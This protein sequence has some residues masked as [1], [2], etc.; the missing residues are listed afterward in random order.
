MEIRIVM[1]CGCEWK[2]HDLD[3]PPVLNAPCHCPQHGDVEIEDISVIGVTDFFVR[4]VM[5]DWWHGGRIVSDEE[6]A[7]KLANTE[8]ETFPCF[9]KSVPSSLVVIY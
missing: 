2:W 3:V 8:H 7:S 6:L 5:G 4:D 1:S 9:T